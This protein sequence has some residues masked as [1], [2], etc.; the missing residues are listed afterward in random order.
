[1]TTSIN[2][3]NPNEGLAICNHV[4]QT[5]SDDGKYKNHYNSDDKRF[6]VVKSDNINIP[7][8]TIILVRNRSII[9]PVKL[10]EGYFYIIRKEDILLTVQDMLLPKHLER[11]GWKKIDN[12]SKYKGIVF[13][14]KKY[15][16]IVVS[17]QNKNVLEIYNEKNKKIVLRTLCYSVYT[18]KYLLVTLNNL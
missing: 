1:M 5:I 11:L 12:I 8:H 7:Q 9:E 10:L 15:P 14:H 6:H 17:L 18:F 16:N 4:N 13:E 2:E 3:V